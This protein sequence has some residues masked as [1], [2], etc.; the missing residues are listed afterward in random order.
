M[1]HLGGALR[2]RTPEATMEIV[3]PL[4]ETAG[5]SRIAD[6]TGLDSL[7]IP[8]FTCM[9]P[10]SK[11]VSTSQGKG[12]TPALARCSAIMEAI[13]HYYAETCHQAR[14]KKP[15]SALSTESHLDPRRL[16]VGFYQHHAL[17]AE[18]FHWIDAIDLFS[19]DTIAV[20]REAFQFDFAQQSSAYGLFNIS[21]TGL[22]SGN[23][24]LEAE[25]HAIFEM[26]ERHALR[27][28]PKLS[29]IDYANKIINLDT[30][31][32]DEINTLI[33]TLLSNNTDLTLMDLTHQF[34]VPV[35]HCT[36]TDNNPFRNLPAFS[37]S[38]AHTDVAI[39]TLRAIT[40]AAQSRLTYIAGSRDD[41]FSPTYQTTQSSFSQHGTRDYTQITS[42]TRFKDMAHLS[43]WLRHHLETH[44]IEQLLCIKHTDDSVPISVLHL[45]APGLII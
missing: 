3:T 20:P 17:S 15:F 21:T 41:L 27:E 25:C 13:E 19:N 10:L 16:N 30:V 26:I 36:I 4:L 37:G 39:A 29:A 12:V 6:L 45:F 22:A 44:G 14:Y 24:D 7:N 8:V 35:I 9:R 11:H 5:I 34:D 18:P 2:E 38:G 1:K 33:D 40:E 28:L 42:H 23:S 43:K 32:N 31:D